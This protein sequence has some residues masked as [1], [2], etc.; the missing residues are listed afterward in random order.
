MADLMRKTKREL[1]AFVQDIEA[2]VDEIDG[3]KSRLEASMAAMRR[4][5]AALH[6][7]LSDARTVIDQLRAD[8]EKARK[9]TAGLEKEKIDK[10]FMEGGAEKAKKVRLRGENGPVGEV[11][12]KMSRVRYQDRP[13]LKIVIQ[14]A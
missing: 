14:Q 8:A 13:S 12:L 6:D 9:T 7:Q 11:K 4:E 2:R 5:H 10:A 3:E 1:V